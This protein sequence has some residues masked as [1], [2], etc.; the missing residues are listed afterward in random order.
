MGSQDI[1]KISANRELDA[2]VAERVIGWHRHI[3][4]TDSYAAGTST[5]AVCGRLL[6]SFTNDGRGHSNSK[7]LPY[8]STDIAAAWEAVKHILVH[9]RR[10]L[11][12]RAKIV[13]GRKYQY[14]KFVDCGDDSAPVYGACATSMPLAICRAA[15]KATE[16]ST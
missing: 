9:D 1:D 6:N 11:Q 3:P 16:T 10:L 13:C 14:A 12:F 2:L 5:C 7:N 15:L 8:Y 4:G